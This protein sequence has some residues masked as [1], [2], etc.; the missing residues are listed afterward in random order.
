VA[1]AELSR[2]VALAEGIGRTR[3]QW[4]T[5]NALA[6]VCVARGERDAAQ[7]H[8]VKA[9]ALAAAITASL[10]SSGLEARLRPTGDSG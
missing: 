1:H 2:A 4:D 8:Q 9:R 10:G 6:R 7:Q 5:A 3:L